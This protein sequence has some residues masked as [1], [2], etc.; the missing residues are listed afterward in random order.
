MNHVH[1]FLRD[2]DKRWDAPAAE[3]RIERRL[4]GSTALFL[5]TSYARRT[6]DGDILETDVIRGPVAARL[7][8]LAG[9]DSDLYVRHRMY[10]DVVGASTP[11]L[12]GRARLVWRT[13]D[14]DHPPRSRGQLTA[15]S[16]WP[17]IVAS[18]PRMEQRH[19]KLLPPLSKVYHSQSESALPCCAPL[20]NAR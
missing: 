14:P 16:R 13:G 8:E 20:S 1:E 9:L 6:K 19:F 18:E 4:I 5:Q 3:G 7:K 11:L 15:R 2:V 12:P 17:N 10:L